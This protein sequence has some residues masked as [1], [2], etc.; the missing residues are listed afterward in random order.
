MARALLIDAV[1]REVR[2]L[3]LPD[4]EHARLAVLQKAVGGYLEAAYAWPTGDVLFVD[5][6]GDRHAART[7]FDFLPRF[8][9]SE[10]R[11]RGSGVVVGREVEGSETWANLSPVITA[12]EL[13]KIVRFWRA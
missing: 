2:E 6:D 5:E 4:D 1:A 10:R 13:A 7:G 9:R 11:L 12:E 8:I 3:D